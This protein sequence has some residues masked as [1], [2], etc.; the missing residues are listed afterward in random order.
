MQA[1][2]ADYLGRAPVS[3]EVM[4]GGSEALLNVRLETSRIRPTGYE[5]LLFYP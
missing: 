1:E 4:A 5:L 3:G 2:P